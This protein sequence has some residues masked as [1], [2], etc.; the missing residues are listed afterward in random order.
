MQAPPPGLKF[1]GR[2]GGFV[3]NVFDAPFFEGLMQCLAAAGTHVSAIAGAD[4]EHLDLLR[5]S[6]RVAE[7][8]VVSAR[9]RR[10]AKGRAKRPNVCE[11]IEMRL[12]D[13]PGLSAAQRKTSHRPMV[14]VGNGAIG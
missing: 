9:N 2:A 10:I 7:Q 6:R 1:M 11:E 8:P 3:V 14:A 4:E 12:R 5:E 13:L